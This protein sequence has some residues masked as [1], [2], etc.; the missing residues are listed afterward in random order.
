MKAITY[1]LAGM[2]DL[3]RSELP[4]IR[5]MISAAPDRTRPVFG[6]PEPAGSAMKIIAEVKKSS[7]SRGGI[8]G[9]KPE[10]QAA[11]YAEGGAAA[12]SVLTDGNFFSGSWDD[13]AGVSGSAALPVLCKEFV[14]FEEQIDLAYLRGA[15]M[16]LLIARALEHN[17]LERLYTHAKKSGLTP[18]V[19][20]H[21]PPELPL[22]LELGPEQIMVNMRN[23]ETLRIDYITGFR[24]LGLLPE[25]VTGI[26]ASGIAARDD[27]ITVHEKTGTRCFLVGTSLMEA[28]DP[29]E[30]LKELCNVY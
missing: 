2:R 18:L 17:E 25:H 10:E 15:D 11:L 26:C 9:V 16:V 19:E 14:Y 12:I 27:I 6:F 3:K 13:L 20:I 4:E 5:K 30:K 28:A 1:S 7:P 21:N 24:T 29:R 8:S 22:V 23:L